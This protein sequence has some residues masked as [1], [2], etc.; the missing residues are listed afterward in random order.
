MESPLRKE[1]QYY[2]DHQ[3]ELVE[4]FNGKHIVIKDCVVVGAYDNELAAVNDAKNHDLK[5][6]T[7]LVQFVSPGDR[8]YKQTF[9]SRV[10]HA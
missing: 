1:F 6:G 5:P 4:Q 3:K 10:I 2:L 9:H 8:A 7:F